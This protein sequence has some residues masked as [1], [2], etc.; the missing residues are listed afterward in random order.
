VSQGYKECLLTDQDEDQNLT[1]A[2]DIDAFYLI[3][4]SGG[5]KDGMTLMGGN[6]T[7]D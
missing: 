3:L 4:P 5:C 6:P 7:G 1:F 2:V